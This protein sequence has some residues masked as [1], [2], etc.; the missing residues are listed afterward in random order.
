MTHGDCLGLYRRKSAS[1][2]FFRP[3]MQPLAAALS[4]LAVSA[5]LNVSAQG[6]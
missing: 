3:S 1:E 6:G 2:P 4:P 5:P